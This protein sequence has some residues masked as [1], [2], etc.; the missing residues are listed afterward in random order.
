M[1]KETI[2]N[3]VKVSALVAIF[4]VIFVCL[5]IFVVTYAHIPT[6]HVVK[7]TLDFLPSNL[8]PDQ[9]QADEY[10]S[11]TTVVDDY[12]KVK[13]G[14]LNCC[15][16]HLTVIGSIL[17]VFLGGYG[18]ASLPMEYLNSYLNRPQIRDAEDYILTKF[19]LRERI[20]EL[21]KDAKKV[22][23]EKEDLNKVV[24]AIALRAKKMELQKKI[25]KLKIDYLEQEEVLDCFVEELNM[26][27]VNP[28][29][30][31]YYLVVGCIGYLGSFLIIFHTYLLLT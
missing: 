16:L 11:N 14:F 5:Y 29:Q 31:T 7:T 21:I 27:N 25:N 10:Y 1:Q 23:R 26:Q 28:L 17:L 19:V 24:G 12:V 13:L 9:K 15:T 8:E 18:L 20:E 30:Y 2:K 6:K 22:K 4:H 3:A